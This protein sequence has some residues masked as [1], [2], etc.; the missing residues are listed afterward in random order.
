M[1]QFESFMDTQIL[2]LSLR[3]ADSTKLHNLLGIAKSQ[4][5]V[6]EEK[7]WKFHY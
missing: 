5:S 2:F 4:F 3:S 1:R 7:A 6:N